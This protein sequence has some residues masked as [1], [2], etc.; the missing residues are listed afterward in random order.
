[1]GT[2]A[3][4]RPSRAQ[5]G[6]L[7]VVTAILDSLQVSTLPTNSCCSR[8]RPQRPQGQSL[9]DLCD[10]T[11]EPTEKLVFCLCFEGA[12][13]QP[14]RKSRKI[15][16]GFSRR[17]AAELIKMTFSAASK[18]V[19]FPKPARTRVFPQPVNSCPSQNTLESEFFRKLLR[20]H[21]PGSWTAASQTRTC[22]G[23]LRRRGLRPWCLCP[24]SL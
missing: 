12:R 9:A 24:L 6:S 1:M 5:L 19:P 23:G 21:R 10:T 15:N 18:L 16:G 4:A 20:V 11:E 14:R 22:R 17:R 7:S 13:L 8:S 3:L 2:G